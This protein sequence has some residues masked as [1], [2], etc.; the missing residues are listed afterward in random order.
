MPSC[1]VGARSSAGPVDIAFSLHALPRDGSRGQGPQS[2]PPQNPAAGA[3]E[4]GCFSSP[5][6][7]LPQG[8]SR[9]AAGEKTPPIRRSLKLP[10]YPTPVSRREGGHWP[11]AA[12]SGKQ[13]PEGADFPEAGAGLFPGVFW[14]TSTLGSKHLTNMC[15]TCMLCL[16]P[17]HPANC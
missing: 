11:S 10:P 1:R 12:L 8:G 4:W 6:I 15:R 7:P 2:N 3:G 16:Q 5:C 14:I 9:D 13:L 17:G